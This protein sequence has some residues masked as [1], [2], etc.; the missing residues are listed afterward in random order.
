[1]LLPLR[2]YLKG[3]S[4]DSLIGISPSQAGQ[5]LAIVQEIDRAMVEVERTLD[6][7]AVRSRA[8]S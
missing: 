2:R 5:L 1:M 4:E 8:L 7:R 6:E 3:Y